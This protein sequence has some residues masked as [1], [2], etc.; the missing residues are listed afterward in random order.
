MTESMFSPHEIC[1]FAGTPGV[2]SE[3]FMGTPR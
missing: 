2:F 1:D 3:S